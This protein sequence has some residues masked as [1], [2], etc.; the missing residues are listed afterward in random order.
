VHAVLVTVS[1]EPGHAEESQAHLVANVI[2]RV[3]EAPGIV[4][5]YWTRSADGEHGSATVVFE[6]EEAARAA[7]ESLPNAPRPD[8]VTFDS[9]EVREVVAQI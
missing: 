3:K 2:P 1:I 7:A 8:S 5:G 9:V 4:S 6:N